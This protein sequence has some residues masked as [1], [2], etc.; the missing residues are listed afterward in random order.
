MSDFS[1]TGVEVVSIHRQARDIAK[2]ICVPYPE[3][4]HFLYKHEPEG[5]C[6]CVNCLICQSNLEKIQKYMKSTHI[7]RYPV[8]AGSC[9]EGMPHSAAVHCG[10]GEY[11]L[12]SKKKE[13]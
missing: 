7:K 1:M 9:Q 2:E 13:E 3:M 12:E 4:L 6:R 10:M 8:S 5:S 11:S